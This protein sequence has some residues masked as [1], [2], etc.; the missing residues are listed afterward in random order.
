MY[1]CYCCKVLLTPELAICY[2]CG[3]IYRK[4]PQGR[5]PP[6]AHASIPIV[7]GHGTS[8]PCIVFVQIHSSLS[9]TGH[10][11]D[12]VLLK[13]GLLCHLT[14]TPL[15]STCTRDFLSGRERQLQL[16]HLLSASFSLDERPHLSLRK[17]D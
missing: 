2:P 8:Q 9:A 6:R 3:Y 12:T 7:R 13:T 15:L 1:T 14:H 11:A 16:D 17:R 4:Y 10:L 5:L